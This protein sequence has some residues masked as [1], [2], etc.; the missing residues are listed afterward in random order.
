VIW[1]LIIGTVLAIVVVFLM[2]FRFSVGGEMPELR[3]PMAVLQGGIQL[4]DRT[5]SK[6]IEAELRLDDGALA[7]MR[8]GDGLVHLELDVEGSPEGEP[9]LVGVSWT[10]RAEVLRP[11]TPLAAGEDVRWA[12]ACTDASSCQRTI[13]FQIALPPAAGPTEVAWRLVAEVR[14]PRE[15]EVPDVAIVQLT[16][17]DGEQ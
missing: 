6:R 11:V 3:R 14:P 7:A 1:G 4:D 9:L 2:S 16:P 17:V 12:L 10:S 5:T 13:G 8:E 15:S